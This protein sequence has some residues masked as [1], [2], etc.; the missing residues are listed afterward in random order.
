MAYATLDDGSER[1]ILLHDA[2]QQLKLKGQT[3]HLSLRTVRHDA[4]VIP[5]ARVS[6]TL[7]PAFQPNKKFKIK[8]AFTAENL[9][10]AK[11]SHPVTL[12]QRK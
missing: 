7:S 4:Q 12:L 5:G 3:E 6:F 8:G 2:A 10:L 11:H 9:G 1:T